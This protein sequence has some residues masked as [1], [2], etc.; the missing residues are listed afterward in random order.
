MS[1]PAS[2]DVLTQAT[3]GVVTGRLPAYDADVFTTA[4]TCL[5]GPGFFPVH[6]GRFAG[7]LS[8][9]G[10]SPRVVI[11]GTDW[12]PREGAPPN[13]KKPSRSLPLSLELALRTRTPTS[14]AFDESTCARLAVISTTLLTSRKF[15]SARC[16]VPDAIAGR[17]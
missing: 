5:G 2:D 12:G 11:F 17:P 4:V 3:G 9:P 10:S 8:Q 1:T 15:L 14:L 13:S 6:S 16:G 7:R